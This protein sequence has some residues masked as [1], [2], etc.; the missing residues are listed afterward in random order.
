MPFV[1]PTTPTLRRDREQILDHINL[2]NVNFAGFREQV[3]AQVQA[4]IDSFASYIAQ[5]K[6]EITV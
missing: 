3:Q 2:D 6:D 5:H 4:T 1:S